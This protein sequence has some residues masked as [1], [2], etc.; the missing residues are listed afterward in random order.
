MLYGRGE[1]ERNTI[2]RAIGLWLR[3]GLKERRIKENTGHGKIET[4]RYYMYVTGIFGSKCIL[5]SHTMCISFLF[6]FYEI[7]LVPGTGRTK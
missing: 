1:R 4:Q 2:K 5:I 6:L 7:R 3:E